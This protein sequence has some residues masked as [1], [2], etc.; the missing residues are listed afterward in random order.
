MGYA[1]TKNRVTHD[2]TTKPTN[3]P[4]HWHQCLPL[5]PFLAPLPHSGQGRGHV[6]PTVPLFGPNLHILLFL[7]SAIFGF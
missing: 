1:I 2:I 7:V 5:D 6:H 3:T 4:Y